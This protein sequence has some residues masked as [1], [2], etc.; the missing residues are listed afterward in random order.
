MLNRQPLVP[1]LVVLN[2]PRSLSFWTQLIGF[3][4]LFERPEDTFA[5]LHLEGAQL[6][7]E[8]LDDEAR[9]RTGELDRPLGRGINFAINVATIE[10]ALGRLLDAGWPLFMN[11]EEKWY[12][13]GDREIGLKQ[14]LV[15]DPDGY[16]L[17]L[18]S[19]LGHRPLCVG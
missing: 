3:E 15:Q 2:L 6:M 4:I 14:F 10:P 18:T 5:Y 19:D 8:Q 9:W 12:R 13:G 16:L 17:R 11:V 1:E 7:L